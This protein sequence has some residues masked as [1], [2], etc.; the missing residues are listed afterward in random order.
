R[1]NLALTCSTLLASTAISLAQDSAQPLVLDTV[2]I[3]S[4]SNDTLVQDGYVAKRDREGTKI[5]TDT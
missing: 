3:Q 5:D 2:T 1:L 4:Q